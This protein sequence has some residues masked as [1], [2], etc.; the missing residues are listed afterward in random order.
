MPASALPTLNAILNF[1][2]AVLLTAGYIFIKKRRIEAHKRCMIAAL[3]VSVAFLTSYVVY[4][5]QV[6]S[7]PFGGQ[8][9]IRPVYFFI[10]ISHIILAI[11]N[12]PLV[13]RTSYLGFMERYDKHVVIARKTFPI[14][15]YVSVTGVIVYVMLYHL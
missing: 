4:H 11:V 8:G 15:M 9:W 13:L 10:L 7:V 3:F 1:T 5:L 14:W 12:L 2:A 6:R